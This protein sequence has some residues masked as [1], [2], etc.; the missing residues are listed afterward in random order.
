MPRIDV[1][2]YKLAPKD[3]TT[4]QSVMANAAEVRALRQTPSGA[5]GAPFIAES[6]QPAPSIIAAQSASPPA[7]MTPIFNTEPV[8]EFLPAIQ[9]ITTA[10]AV[11]FGVSYDEVFVAIG[12]TP[13]AAARQFAAALCVRRLGITRHN[14]ADAFGV[15]EAIVSPALRDLD[16][17]LVEHQ[18]S[19]FSPLDSVVELVHC[20]WQSD[21]NRLRSYRIEEIQREVCRFSGISRTE[22]LSNRR[23]RN[24]VVPRQLAMALAKHLTARSLPEIGRA[25]GGRDH[26]TV[27]HAVRK[28]SP[29]MDS[30]AGEVEP[31]AELSL[32][33]SSAFR[34]VNNL[35]VGYY[36]PLTTAE[37]A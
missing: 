34:H 12:D 5:K 26:T 37:A 20:R 24:L 14:A 6:K 23:T 32:W 19:K 4:A 36:L 3:L 21:R 35:G 31:G 11:Q 22:I 33:V 10:F 7:A 13:A 1:T 25:F 2:G 16:V 9:A 29:V 28:M 27:L 18:I 8:A 15:V 17:V 30:A